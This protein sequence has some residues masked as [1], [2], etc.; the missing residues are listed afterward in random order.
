MHIGTTALHFGTNLLYILALTC[1]LY[2]HSF[3]ITFQSFLYA[4]SLLPLDLVNTFVYLL[5]LPFCM[6]RQFLPLHICT[7]FLYLL[8]NPS[9]IYWH[10]LPLRIGTL[11]LYR[12]ALPSLLSCHSLPL[13]TALPYFIDR[14]CLSLYIL[15]Y[16]GISFLWCLNL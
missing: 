2:W 1:S 16:S 7:S 10:F 5:A 13:L 3:L 14:H 12:L 9:F 6:H 11:F 8:E 15:V 4:V